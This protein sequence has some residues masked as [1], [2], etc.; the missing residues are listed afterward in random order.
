M[1]LFGANV[2]DQRGD[3]HTFRIKRALNVKQ[4]L[5][6]VTLDETLLSRLTMK[7]LRFRGNSRILPSGMNIALA[8]ARNEKL[9]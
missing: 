9:F 8:P 3:V 7:N 6:T 4:G 1:K 5:M 2:N